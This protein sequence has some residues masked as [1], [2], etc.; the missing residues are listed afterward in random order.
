MADT[1]KRYNAGERV[2]EHLTEAAD[3]GAL[4][5]RKLFRGEVEPTK[6]NLNLATQARG[7][8]GG[9]TRYEATLSAREQNNIIL[10]RF[11]AAED[12]EEFKR[13]VKASMPEHPAVRVVDLKLASGE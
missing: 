13:Y 9:F 2:R 7:A 3:E 5:L 4:F 1:P 12:P 10:S 11:L 6:E 8:V